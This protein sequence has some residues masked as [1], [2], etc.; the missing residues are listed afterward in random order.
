[1][2]SKVD[3]FITPTKK[4]KILIQGMAGTGKTELLL[5]KLKEIYYSQSNSKIVFTCHNKVLAN[6]M[7]KRIP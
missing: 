6:D 3:L 2:Q 7:K 4:N 5:H 1:M